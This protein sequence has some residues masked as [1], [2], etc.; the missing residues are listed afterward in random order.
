MIDKY[1]DA[2]RYVYE[3]DLKGKYTI[4]TVAAIG[5]G[6][7]GGGDR[8]DTINGNGKNASATEG[9]SSLLEGE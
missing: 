5:H 1:T 2:N 7:E 9:G 8:D 6:Y 3:G 4:R